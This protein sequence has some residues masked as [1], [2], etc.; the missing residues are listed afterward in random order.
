MINNIILSGGWGYGNIG[1]EAIL[2]YTYMDIKKVLPNCQITVL[3][4]NPEETLYHHSINAEFSLHRILKELGNSEFDE[5]CRKILNEDKNIPPKIKEYEDQLSEG[6][7]F[8]MAGGG[9]FND[10]WKESFLAHI[11]EIKIAKNKGT[12][13]AIIGQTIGPFSSKKNRDLISNILDQVD[14]I[15]VRDKTSYRLLK[16]ILPG[17]PIH[18]SCDA[19]VRNGE[20]KHQQSNNNIAVMFQRK[21]PFTNTKTTKF[22]YRASQIVQLTTGQN[23]KFTKNMCELVMKLHAEYPDSKIVFLESTKWHED[24]IKKMVEQSHADGYFMGETVDDYIDEI[25][26]TSCVISTNMHPTIFA[27]TM[28]IPAIAISHTYKMDDY[29]KLIDQKRC[30]FYDIRVDEIFA[31]VKKIIQDE[32]NTQMLLSKNTELCKKLDQ[33]YLELRYICEKY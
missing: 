29:M 24:K 17:K 5:Y 13:V 22:H 30:I 26:K 6:T 7:L 1:D 19:V 9:Y 31:E 33:T 2:K 16:K 11:C 3:S 8:V 28:G 25:A 12:K 4:Y 15:D 27:T 23:A 21:R 14:Y 18:L 10:H 20:Y 32:D